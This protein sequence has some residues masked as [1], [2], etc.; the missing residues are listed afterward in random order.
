MIIRCRIYSKSWIATIVC[1]LE[2]TFIWWLVKGYTEI[3]ADVLNDGL[4]V[5]SFLGIISVPRMNGLA[6]ANNDSY[7]RGGQ[8]VP[9]NW[10][11][12]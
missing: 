3:I 4:P 9:S 12:E 5:S 11:I 6:G 7:S 8:N 10:I 1:L 2:N